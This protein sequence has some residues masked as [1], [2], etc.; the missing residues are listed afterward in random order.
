MFIVLTFYYVYATI[1]SMTN[2]SVSHIES[3]VHAKSR[4]VELGTKAVSIL[5]AGSLLAACGE[6]ESSRYS[7]DLDK[8]AVGI[9]IC[10]GATIRSDPSVREDSSSGETNKLD[11]TDYG[12]APS[13]TCI[14]VTSDKVYAYDD[15]D[16]GEFY[17]VPESV[18]ATAMPELHLS[19]DDTDDI[20]WL[21][22]QK[23]SIV[24]K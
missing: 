9:S 21:N 13:D 22:H 8:D 5:L 15:S 18:L 3:K 16:N 10:D 6:S 7:G 23:A 19:K 20:V 4:T 17:G 1:L 11:V 2:E 14:T 24:D 12:D